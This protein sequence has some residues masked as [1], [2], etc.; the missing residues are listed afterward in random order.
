MPRWVSRPETMASPMFARMPAV[1]TTMSTS[2]VVPP[3]KA[4]PVTAPSGDLG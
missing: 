4:T 2:S 3:E 1:T